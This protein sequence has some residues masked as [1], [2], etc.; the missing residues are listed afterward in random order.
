VNDGSIVLLER[1]IVHVVPQFEKFEK[2]SLGMKSEFQ[3][4]RKF[5]L[6]VGRW[7]EDVV[8]EVRISK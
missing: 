8:S 5:R 2:I 6:G 7:A 3:N 1:R 4:D